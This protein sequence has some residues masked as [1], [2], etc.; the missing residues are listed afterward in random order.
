MPI[1][2]VGRWVES[3][4]RAAARSCLCVVRLNLDS[5]AGQNRKSAL[6]FNRP[7]AGRLQFRASQFCRLA[8]RPRAGRNSVHNYPLSDALRAAIGAEG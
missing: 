2:I 7:L 1:P 5:A 4:T 8:D 3:A 6:R